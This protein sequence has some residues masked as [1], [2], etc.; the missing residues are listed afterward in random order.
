MVNDDM[1][2]A[3]LGYKFQ[4]DIRDPAHLFI[5]HHTPHD[6]VNLLLG[7]IALVATI[8]PYTCSD[9]TC[10]A[11]GHLAISFARVPSD[12]DKLAACEAARMVMDRMVYAD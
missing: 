1:N 12:S 11:K 6:P 7:G 10:P 8:G 3:Q 4:Q 5:E 9:G 2:L